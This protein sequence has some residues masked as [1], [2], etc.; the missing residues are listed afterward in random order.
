MQVAAQHAEA[1][2]ECSGISVEKRLLLDGI[3]LGARHVSPG[4]KQRAAAVV[5]DLADAWLA[6]GDGA[7]MAAGKA[8]HPAIIELFV[9]ARISL[10][11]AFV[12]KTA[13]GGHRTSGI[14]LPRTENLV[15]GTGL[16]CRSGTMALQPGASLLLNGDCLGPSHVRGQDCG[17]SLA[18]VVATGAGQ[19]NPEVGFIQVLGHAASAPVK[20][21]QSE[22]GADISL[23]SGFGEPAKR[24]FL[25]E[26]HTFAG[27]VTKTE[28]IFGG[29]IALLG[30]LLQLREG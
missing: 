25:V 26:F 13:K 1:V 9:E 30:R 22:L 14:I 2:S 23:L 5:A 28:R 12:E 18:V 15:A 10:L 21:T 20:G 24:F 19:D 8:A 11:N 27:S 3:A 16:R 7:T 4:N 17:Q 6:L 29:G